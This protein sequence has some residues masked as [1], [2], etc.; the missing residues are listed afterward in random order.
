MMMVYCRPLS[1]Y[2]CFCA[3]CYN[4]LEANT[5]PYK[6]C[7]AAPGFEKIAISWRGN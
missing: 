5:G 1:I 7:H 3:D 2:S 6:R 4:K